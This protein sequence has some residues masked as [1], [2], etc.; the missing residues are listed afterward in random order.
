MDFTLGE[1]F[2]GLPTLVDKI[3]GEGMRFIILLVSESYL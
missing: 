2:Q 1:T 3:R